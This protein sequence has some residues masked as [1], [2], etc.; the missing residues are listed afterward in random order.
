MG[1]CPSVL[2]SHLLVDLRGYLSDS[3]LSLIEKNPGMMWPGMTP[4]QAALSSLVIDPE[5][6]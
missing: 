1:V 4:R 2:Y 6:V 5:E 3:D